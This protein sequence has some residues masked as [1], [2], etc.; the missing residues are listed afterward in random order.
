[1]QRPDVR[2][3][4]AKANERREPHTDEAKVRWLRARSPV[5]L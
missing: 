4:L 1:M 2:E 5:P 3:R